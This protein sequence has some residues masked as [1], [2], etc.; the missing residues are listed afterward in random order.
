[1]KITY[2]DAKNARNIRERN[3]PFSLAKDFEFANAIVVQ[4]KRR[5][6]SEIRMKAV[7]NIGNR[8]HVLIFV[9]T[10]EGIRI[11]SL[12]KAN[13]REVKRYAAQTRS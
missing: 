2:D 6:Y 9:P 7:G 3:L 12:R 8:L 11:I 10:F 13:A 5:T 4:D 1:M